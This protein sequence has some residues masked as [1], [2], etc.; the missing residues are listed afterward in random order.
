MLSRYLGV[1][2]TAVTDLR[3]VTLEMR[4]RLAKEQCYWTWADLV[5]DEATSPAGSAREESLSY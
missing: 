3:H 2:L 1:T 4:G 5:K